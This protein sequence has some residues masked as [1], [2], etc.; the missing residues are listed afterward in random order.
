MMKEEFKSKRLN[1]ELPFFSK[2]LLLAAYLA[3]YNPIST[4]KRYFMMRKSGRVIKKSKSKQQSHLKYELFISLFSFF[5][6]PYAIYVVSGRHNYWDQK[7][8]I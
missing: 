1:V 6:L 8:L 7:C 3:S 5:S 2:Y 4:D